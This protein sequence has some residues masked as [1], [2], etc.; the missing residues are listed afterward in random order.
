MGRAASYKEGSGGEGGEPQEGRA[1]DRELQ[2]GS[3][4][5]LVHGFVHRATSKGITQVCSLTT[6]LQVEE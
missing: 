4:E 1:A 6:P 2:E 5:L 3:S